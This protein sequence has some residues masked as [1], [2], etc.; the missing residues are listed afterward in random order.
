MSKTFFVS[1]VDEL[2]LW[3][4]EAMLTSSLAVAVA[5][6]LMPGA[7]PQTAKFEP[8][9]FLPASS[10]AVLELEKPLETLKRVEELLGLSGL[11]P[12][13]AKPGWMLQQALLTNQ[14][15]ANLDLSQPIL[16]ATDTFDEES[17]S[18]RVILKVKD[19]KSVKQIDLG[20]IRTHI[21]KSG[22]II[23]ST[24]DIDPSVKPSK[25]FV[26]PKN[27]YSNNDLVGH[28]DQPAIMA[29]T[30]KGLEAEINKR[31]FG[32]DFV[33]TTVAFRIP[34]NSGIEFITQVE[35]KAG[36][37][38][39]KTSQALRSQ[40]TSEPL[41]T[42]L[43]PGRYALVSGTR[44]DPEMATQI[45]VQMIDKL[46]SVLELLPPKDDLKASQFEPLFV[47][48]KEIFQLG[49][50]AKCRQ[51]SLGIAIPE[52][53]ESA[54]FVMGNKCRPVAL[55]KLLKQ[56][57]TTINHSIK[58]FVANLPK[59]PPQSFGIKS[60]KTRKVGTSQLFSL[61]LT[62]VEKKDFDIPIVVGQTKGGFQVFAVNA[63]PQLVD[64]LLAS[65][66]KQASFSGPRFA[67]VKKRLFK[68]R[69]TEGYI[70]LAAGLDPFLTG[71]F[72]PLRMMVASLPP[73]GFTI[74]I[75]PD[76]SQVS[77]ILIPRQMIPLMAFAF[78]LF[79][80]QR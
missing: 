20:G 41:I 27:V 46:K 14:E 33:R 74:R 31:M 28:F 67:E 26:F 25:S 32:E 8:R 76:D 59:K 72:A 60:Q 9:K 66:P 34:D 11:A 1:A 47:G 68:K 65:V 5:V 6:S 17:P 64:R 43:P 24:P 39:A 63:K 69:A 13:N 30:S 52:S 71:E 29:K 22:W 54:Y 40:Q 56:F 73:I 48:L 7:K 35:P 2:S 42:G 18:F 36:T 61:E 70:D 51:A 75:Q 15:L 78:Q 4:A 37:V 55:G 62:G 79:Q 10:I 16:F 23:A 49:N 53:I 58:D 77:Q 3:H 57:E 45:A 50:K 12:P 19:P 21:N 80:S 38:F 44:S